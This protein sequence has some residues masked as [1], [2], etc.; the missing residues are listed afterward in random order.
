MRTPQEEATKAL[1]RKQDMTLISLILVSLLSGSSQC[2]CKT[3]PTNE[4]SHGANEFIVIPEI[5]VNRI[6][7]KVLLPNEEPENEAILVPD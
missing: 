1:T 3:V 6:A 4:T 7:G 2:D 5:K